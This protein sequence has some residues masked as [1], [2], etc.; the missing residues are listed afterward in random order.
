MYP[1]CRFRSSGS[2][3]NVTCRQNSSRSLRCERSRLGLCDDSMRR[4]QRFVALSG[5]RGV[6]S[7][8]SA[9][10]AKHR[11]ELV[12]FANGLV[13]PDEAGDVVSTVIVK[14]YSSGRSLSELREP[15][16]YLMRAVLNQ[17]RSRRRERSV[18][19]PDPAVMS[20]SVEPEVRQ[21]VMALP[22]RRRAVT[23]LAY[24]VGMASV[25]IAE[26]LGVRPATVRRYLF[27]ARQKLR[28]VLGDDD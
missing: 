26:V 3:V 28:R 21:A 22:T 19:L 23:Y 9:I 25:Q 13:G 27:L 8:D 4:M 15:R 24:W 17:A 18:A 14:L 1:V 12:R 5:V 11:E 2:E 16:S 20:F 6:E 10:Y 7:D